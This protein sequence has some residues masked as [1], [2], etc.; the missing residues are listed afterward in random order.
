M[1]QISILCLFYIVKAL[2]ESLG[3]HI[4]P[5]PSLSTQLNFRKSQ[6]TRNMRLLC[7]WFFQQDFAVNAVGTL[8]YIS[9][10]YK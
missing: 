4:R 9:V 7:K 10:W 5:S 3:R 1:C 6:M 2:V 8:G